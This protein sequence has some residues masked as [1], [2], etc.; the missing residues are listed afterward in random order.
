MDL[1]STY[2]TEKFKHL[3]YEIED[4]EDEKPTPINIERAVENIRHLSEFLIYGHSKQNTYFEMF[5]ERNL[6]E[7][8]SRVLDRGTPEINMQMIQTTSIL[9]QNIEK[10]Q[11]LFYMLSHPF[12]NKLISY[13]F[14]LSEHNEIVDYF[15]SF[16]K[17]LALKINKNSIQFF[18]NSRFKDFPLYGT[19]VNLY[20]HPESM[21][22]T[23]ARTIT[24]TVYSIRDQEL[25]NAVLS[26]PHA[27]YFPHLA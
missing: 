20:N 13:N 21:V 5:A 14:D 1:D 7:V 4:I 24:L 23:A 27:A 8:F 25:I 22:R 11:D 6:L 16:L 2:S 18:Y 10:E 19:A 3:L 15:I 17:M 12:L 26:L 9:I